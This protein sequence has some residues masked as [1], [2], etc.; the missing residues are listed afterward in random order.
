MTCILYSG[1]SEA[2]FRCTIIIVIMMLMMI[3][4]FTHP[5]FNLQKAIG[6][7]MCI[8]CSEWDQFGGFESKYMRLIIVVFK[9]LALCFPGNKCVCTRTK[10]YCTEK[11]HNKIMLICIVYLYFETLSILL[12]TDWPH[13]LLL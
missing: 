4:I 5:L 12:F 3:M 8:Y 10:M 2:I 6:I 13:S 7:T 9:V 1:T 11:K